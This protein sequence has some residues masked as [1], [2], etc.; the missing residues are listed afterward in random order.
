MLYDTI[1]TGYATQRRPDPR[2]AAAINRAL[3]GTAGLL[4]NIGAGAGSYEPLDRPV[5][6]VEPSMTMIRQRPAGSAPSIQAVAEHLP[7]GDKCASA[8][9]AILTMHHWSNIPQG[10]E[11]LARIARDR[12]VLLTWD[13]EFHGFWLTDEYFPAIAV[14]DRQNFPAM[15]EISRVLGS[16]SVHPVPVPH[17]CIDGFLGANWR[18]PHAYLDPAVRSGSSGFSSLAGLDDGLSRL[19][20]DLAS[21]KWQRRFGNV[22]GRESLDLGY[23]VV[24]ASMT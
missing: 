21:G 9:T 17:D 19:R 15:S 11:E 16:I 7:F 23:R 20:D 1:G 13:P 12:V 2:I 8:A 3:S 5:V 6:A 22:L 14:R 24:I 10:L 18:R 4:L